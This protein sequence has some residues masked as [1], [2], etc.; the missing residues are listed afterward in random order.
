MKVVASA[1]FSVSSFISLIFMTRYVGEAYG[2]MMWGM[3]LVAMINSA[4]DIG[5]HSAN[6]K[7]VSEGKDISRCVSTYLAIRAA[8]S[9]VTVCAV[10]SASLL[11]NHFNGGFPAEFWAVTSV[12]ILYFVLDNFLLVMTGTFIGKMDAGKESAVLTTEYLVRAA[13][14]IVFA[15]M[16]AS[17]VI[18]SFGYIAGVAAALIVSFLLF[19]PLKVRLVR[20]A[21]FREYASFAAPLAVPLVL[22]AVIASVDKVIIG[23]YHGEL[24]VGFYT[25]AAGIIY[26]L[27]TLGTVMNGL[28][29]SHMSKLNKEGRRDEARKTL[30]AAQKYLAVLMLPATVFLLMF[31]NEAAVALFKAGFASSGPV[32]SVLGLNIYLAVL[33][34][35]LSQVLLSMNRTVLYG[36]SAAVYA[37]LTLVLFFVLIPGRFFDGPSG[38]VGAA[39]AL[40]IGNFVFVVLLV[41]ATRMAGTF[42]VYPRIY[43]HVA[44][45][46]CVFAMLY[47]I[48]EYLGPS[49]ILWLVALAFLSVAVYAAMLIAVREITKKDILFIRE[50]VSPKNIYEDL[51][52]E[53]RGR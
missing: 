49:G 50:T 44:A 48:K 36:K 16:G 34:G 1:I 32:L 19:R 21:F 33:A 15:V 31:G 52:D 23:M 35:M 41:I 51:K 24:E 5:F 28:L 3:S 17:A 37:V 22:I 42:S 30:W 45:A 14:L 43:I 20:P 7:K 11:M 2:M 38:A 53:M 4:L 18:L 10:L 8:M 12:F 26:S 9:A 25:A 40:V 13:F 27:V 29:L 6:I 39:A 46:L 47:G